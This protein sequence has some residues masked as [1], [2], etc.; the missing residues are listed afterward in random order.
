MCLYWILQQKQNG[1]LWALCPPQEGESHSA[2]TKHDM[3]MQPAGEVRF[4]IKKGVPFGRL[5]R[6]QY[7]CRG[8]TWL[9]VSPALSSRGEARAKKG[10]IHVSES[11]QRRYASLKRSPVF[12]GMAP[13]MYL[14]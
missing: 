3:K 8:S 4:R 10:A 9:Y 1:S 7:G 6:H 5:V 14:I 12:R 11:Q 2:P 13:K